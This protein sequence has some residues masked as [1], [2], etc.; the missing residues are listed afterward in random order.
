MVNNFVNNFDFKSNEAYPIN[1]YFINA[2]VLEFKNLN[3][4]GDMPHAVVFGYS[5]NIIFFNFH[6]IFFYFRK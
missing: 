5:L 1:L 4:D 2:F 6:F 3:L